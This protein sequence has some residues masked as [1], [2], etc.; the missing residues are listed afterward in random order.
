LETYEK[1]RSGLLGRMSIVAQDNRALFH[2]PLIDYLDVEA[3]IATNFESWE[4][5]FLEQSINGRSVHS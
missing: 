4:E 1:I 3:P 2:A 5:A